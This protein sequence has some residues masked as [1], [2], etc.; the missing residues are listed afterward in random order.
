MTTPPQIF[1]GTNNNSLNLNL[2]YIYDAS[3]TGYRTVNSTDFSA[4]IVSGDVI[5]NLDQLQMQISGV[6]NTLITGITSTPIFTGTAA[7]TFVQFNAPLISGANVAHRITGATTYCQ[8]VEFYNPNN[9]GVLQVGT[10]QQ[11]LR[12]LGYGEPISYAAPQGKQLNLADFAFSGS[13][14]G[15]NL[16]VTYFN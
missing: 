3:I 16:V 9:T 13:V 1:Y 14:S 12:G 4:A 6:Q 15:Q 5:M 7:A 10:A 2:Q 8:G 11:Q